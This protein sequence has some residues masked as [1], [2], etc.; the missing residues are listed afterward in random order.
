MSHQKQPFYLSILR[1]ATLIFESS[2]LQFSVCEEIVDEGLG[3]FG[4]GWG[5]EVGRGITGGPRMSM[6]LTLQYGSET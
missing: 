3:V 5:Q 1:K 2:S 6:I 4:L